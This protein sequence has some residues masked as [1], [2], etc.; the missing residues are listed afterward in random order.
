MRKRRQVDGND[1]ALDQSIDHRAPRGTA[2]FQGA[3]GFPLFGRIAVA[4][5][6]QEGLLARVPSR[7]T[8]R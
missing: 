4:G 5:R 1:F 6:R 8:A 3:D 2:K 7:L